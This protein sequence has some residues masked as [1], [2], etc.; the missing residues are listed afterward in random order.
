MKK[1]LLTGLATLLPL[2]LTVAIVLFLVNLLTA[3]FIGMV[4]PLLMKFSLFQQGVGFIS[5][6]QLVQYTSKILILV[7][8][9]GLT[10]A[11]G[12]LAR[13]FFINY[14]IG[15]GDSILHRI[16]LV[17]SVYKTSQDVIQTIFSDKST[18]FKQVALVPFPHAETRSIGLITKESIK[19]HGG[20]PVIA[21]FVPTTPNPTSGFLMLFKREDLVYVDMSVEDA[22]K[23]I[24]SCGVIDCPLRSA[25]GE[26][27]SPTIDRT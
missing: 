14:L 26:S 3:P 18:S 8:L 10:V 16:P 9:F 17:N 24:I 5:G 13:H 12:F 25:P 2:A 11:L 20:D 7:L 19:D 21:V 1:Y 23:Y 15:I 6:E 22:F 27:N 4:K